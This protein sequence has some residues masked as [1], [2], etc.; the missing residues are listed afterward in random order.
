V[1]HH[2]IKTHSGTLMVGYGG[3][4]KKE[5]LSFFKEDCQERLNTSGRKGAAL[6]RRERDSGKG[7]GGTIYNP[8]KDLHS[9]RR[10]S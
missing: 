8:G 3:E 1:D 6:S 5:G 2:S 10:I 9:G 7:W 4:K